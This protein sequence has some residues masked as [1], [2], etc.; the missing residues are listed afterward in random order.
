MTPE[1]AAMSEAFSDS[2]HFLL[3]KS[4]PTIIEMVK[5]ICELDELKGAENIVVLREEDL[6]KLAFV[7][8]GV[9]LSKMTDTVVKMIKDGIIEANQKATDQK[10]KEIKDDLKRRGTSVEKELRRIMESNDE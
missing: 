9:G 7:S 6:I 2:K 4:K 5:D 3:M 8:F 10:A 1:S